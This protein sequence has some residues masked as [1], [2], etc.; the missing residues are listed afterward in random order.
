MP[1]MPWPDWPQGLTVTNSGNT[2][3]LRDFYDPDPGVGTLNNAD[4]LV[5]I[6]G[7]AGCAI[8]DINPRI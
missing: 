6:D 4:P 8:S 5:V 2:P 3:W 7:V 1:R